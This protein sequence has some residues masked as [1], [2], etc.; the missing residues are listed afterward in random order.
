MEVISMATKTTDGRH[1]PREQPT[2]LLWT[3]EETAVGLSVSR[4]SVWRLIALNKLEV[5]RLGRSVR[6]KRSS[7]DALLAGDHHE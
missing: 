7:V 3:V 5:I 2:P 4:R 6:V 1:G